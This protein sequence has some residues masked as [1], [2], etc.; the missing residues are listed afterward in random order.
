L[1]DNISQNVSGLP[2]LKEIPVLGA[3]FRSNAFQRTETEL[4]I[5]VTPFIVRPVSDAASLHLPTDDATVPTDLERLLFQ[6]QVGQSAGAPPVRMRIPGDA[7]FIV[8]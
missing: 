6:R 5:V 4:V 3:L 2:E 7:G 8:Q 1:Q